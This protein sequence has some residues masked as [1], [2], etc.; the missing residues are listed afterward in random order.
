MVLLN[1]SKDLLVLVVATKKEYVQSDWPTQT[2]LALVVCAIFPELFSLIS[3]GRPKPYLSHIS[4]D[5]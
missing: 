4:L 5:A 3:A 2:I 1:Q